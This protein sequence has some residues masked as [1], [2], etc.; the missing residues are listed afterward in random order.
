MH[1]DVRL[2][3]GHNIGLFVLSSV[4]KIRNPQEEL[5]EEHLRQKLSHYCFSFKMK[6]R[7]LNGIKLS[8]IFLYI[9]LCKNIRRIFVVPLD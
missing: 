2:R 9:N 6:W 4:M 5:Q 7:L 3:P 1:R 8:L